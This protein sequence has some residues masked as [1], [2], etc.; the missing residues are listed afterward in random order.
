MLIYRILGVPM[1]DLHSVWP[2][3]VSLGLADHIPGLKGNLCCFQVE[4]AMDL[5]LDTLRLWQRRDAGEQ[6]FD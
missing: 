6:D 1:C 3:S 2:L 4:L 5:G